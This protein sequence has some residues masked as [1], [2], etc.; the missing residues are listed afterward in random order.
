MPNFKWY[1][2]FCFLSFTFDSL[3]LGRV[4]DT[5]I[6]FFPVYIEG[7]K[8][9]QEFMEYFSRPTCTILT[10][11][12]NKELWFWKNRSTL[13]FFVLISRIFYFWSKCHLHVEQEKEPSTVMSGVKI[14]NKTKPPNGRECIKSV[15]RDEISG[16]RGSTTLI[17]VGNLL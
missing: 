2:I 7:G 13:H 8:A 10:L 9:V 16:Q 1:P 17:V 14:A 5:Y 12:L 11:Q 4:L 15:N 6:T 3:F